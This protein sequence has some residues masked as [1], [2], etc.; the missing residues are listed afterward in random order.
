[1]PYI[2]SRRA[3][4]CSRCGA[5]DHTKRRCAKVWPRPGPPRWEYLFLEMPV[6]GS[7]FLPD[8]YGKQGWELVG[9]L[10]ASPTIDRMWFKRTVSTDAQPPEKP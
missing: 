5:L 8:A 4:R 9:V 2:Q 10:A 7:K 1:M 3:P 6:N